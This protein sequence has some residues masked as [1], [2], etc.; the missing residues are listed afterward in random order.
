[1]RRKIT[2]VSNGKYRVAVLKDIETNE[3]IVRLYIDNKPRLAA[4]YFTDDIVDAVGTMS[5]MLG[6]AVKKNITI[7]DPK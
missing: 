1:M 7:E 2:N 4:D 5:A 3:Y 6:E